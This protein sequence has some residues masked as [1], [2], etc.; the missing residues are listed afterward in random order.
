MPPAIQLTLPPAAASG[1]GSL[2]GTAARYSAA[3]VFETVPG[4]PYLA[5]LPARG[6][7]ADMIG[8]AFGILTELYAAT[9]PSGWRFAEHPG[10][11]TRRAASFLGEDLDALE[12]RATDYRGSLKAAVAGPWTLAATVEL[13]HGDK[14]LSDPGACRDIAASLADGLR[15]HV[16][17]LRKRVPGL[18]TLVI[19]LDEPALPAV[20]RGSVPTASGFGTLSAIEPAV[21]RAALRTVVDVLAADD[22]AVVVH[23]CAADVPVEL[24]REAGIAGLA[25]D[26]AYPVDE[27]AWGEFLEARGVLLAGVVPSAPGATLPSAQRCAEPVRALFNRLGLPA[28]ELGRVVPVPACGLAAASNEHVRAVAQLCADAAKVLAEAAEA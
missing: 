10:R 6:P 27:T 24:L 5:E 3:M 9:E 19:A 20:L 7:G 23:C 25:V 8:R 21:V 12:E 1:I 18:E 14:A 28:R 15:G 17:E 4:L 26:L 11:E 2:P 22:V 13:R 16:V